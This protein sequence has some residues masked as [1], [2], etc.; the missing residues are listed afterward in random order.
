MLEIII[1]ILLSIGV[2]SD[3]SDIKI[4]SDT[5]GPDGTEQVTFADNSNGNV[6]SLIG[7]EQNGWGIQP[8]GAAAPQP[9][10]TEQNG[11]GVQ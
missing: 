10:G 1:A 7:T 9:I 3:G 5:I 4:M 2:K 6:Y 8:N 11:W